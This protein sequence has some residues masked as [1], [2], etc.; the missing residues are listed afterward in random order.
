MISNIS[1]ICTI[2]KFFRKIEAQIFSLNFLQIFKSKSYRKISFI[3]KYPDNR[4]NITHL[5][6]LSTT[7]CSF[8]SFAIVVEDVDSG[9]FVVEG[10]FFD[11]PGGFSSVGLFLLFD[12]FHGFWRGGACCR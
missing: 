5:L 8:I 4:P 10:V 11:V 3:I 12:A 1:R 9:L 2:S 7:F 6:I